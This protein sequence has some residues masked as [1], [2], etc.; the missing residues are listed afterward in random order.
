M[1]FKIKKK[2]WKILGFSLCGLAVIAGITTFFVFKFNQNP[3]EID[4]LPKHYKVSVE[5]AVE[6]PGDY[7]FDQPLTVREIIFQAVVKTNADT[8]SLDLDK[9]IDKDTN[10][11]VPF[12][13][14]TIEKIKW[15]DLTNVDQ[16]TKYG[17]KK[18]VALKIIQFRQQNE[19]TTWEQIRAIKGIGETTINQLKEIIDLS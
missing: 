1:K 8:S 6:N 18:S 16:L 19:T 2:W 15:K 7:E 5:G 9:T 4:K 11:L 12:K 3:N 10:I 17:V 14:G 13:I